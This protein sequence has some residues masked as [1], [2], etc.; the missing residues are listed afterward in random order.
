M[1]LTKV[2]IKKLVSLK[3]K[4]GRRTEDRFLAEGVRLLEEALRADYRP[5]IVLYAPGEVTERGQNVIR[6]FSKR[7]INTITVAVKEI[8]KISDTDTPQGIVAVFKQRHT[9]FE[10][11]LSQSPRT[12]VVCDGVGDPGNL[13][14]LLRSALAFGADAVVTTEGSAEATNPKTIRASMGSFFH[15]P[16]ISGAD[17]TDIVGLLKRHTYRIAVADVRGQAISA[18]GDDGEKTAIVIGSEPAGT[19][20]VF[21]AAAD[22]RWKIPMTAKVE[23]LNAAMAG[24]ILLYWLYAGRKRS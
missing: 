9:S 4:K 11:L 7:R 20:S 13:G 23:S 15:L 21:A 1:A 5:E 14:T 2:E 8:N 17:P 16:I 24:S 3:S 18:G 19:G 10:K 6:S 22:Q 12:I